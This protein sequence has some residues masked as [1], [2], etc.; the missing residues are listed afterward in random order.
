MSVLRTVSTRGK[1]SDLL[2]TFTLSQNR[3]AEK[4]FTLWFVGR[5]D[6]AVWADPAVLTDPFVRADQS[7]GF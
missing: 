5:T 7:Y 3:A 6:T 1:D 4:F 2:V